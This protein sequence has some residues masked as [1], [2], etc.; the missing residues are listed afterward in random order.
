M[1]KIKSKHSPALL[2]T[3]LVFPGYSAQKLFAVLI[4]CCGFGE[5]N[6]GLQ[7]SA[8]LVPTVIDQYPLL[9]YGFRIKELTES[10]EIHHGCE[11]NNAGC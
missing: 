8:V 1:F 5:H 9:R 3:V 7:T 2:K 6:H 4:I 10:R 11:E